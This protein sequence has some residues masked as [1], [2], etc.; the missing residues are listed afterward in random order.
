MKLRLSILL[1]VAVMFAACSKE[2]P[3]Y[4]RTFEN[5]VVPIL[6]GEHELRKLGSFDRVS[7]V[8]EQKMSSGYFLLVGGEYKSKEI[9]GYTT[10]EN[11]VKLS[12]KTKDNSYVTIMLPSDRIRPRFKKDIQTRTVEF[13]YWN[14]INE[15]YSR[16]GYRLPIIYSNFKDIKKIVDDFVVYA[17]VN[18]REEDWPEEIK[19][20]N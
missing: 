2:K 6:Q 16:Q 1:A 18:C 8:P 4:E 12:W 13:V 5:S 3:W 19:L 10:T 20:P 14:T 7:T 15:N 17:I 11:L 9:S